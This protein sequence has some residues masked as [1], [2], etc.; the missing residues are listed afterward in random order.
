[1]LGFLRGCA[2]GGWGFCWGMCFAWDILG[3]PGISWDI[4]GYPGIS[5]AKRK[6]L[7]PSAAISWDILG[8]PGICWDILG[9]PGITGGILGYMGGAG[10]QQVPGTRLAHRGFA[11]HPR[12]GGRVGV[13]VTQDIPG[14]PRISQDISGYLR[15][16]QDISGWSQDISGYLRICPH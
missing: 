10:G 11:G 2:L 6:G 8:Y 7:G 9:Y 12:T 4:L 16:S 5:W 13:G 15:I 14:Y 1:M 3:Y